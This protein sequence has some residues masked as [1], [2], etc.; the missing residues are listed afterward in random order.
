M[1]SQLLFVD[2]Y[3]DTLE[4]P[5][6]GEIGVLPVEWEH[7]QIVQHLGAQY[8]VVR[9]LGRGGMG[10]VFLARDIALHRLVAIKVCGSSSRPRSNTASASA[11]KR[12]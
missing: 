10:V 1:S 9:E 4:L 11:A 7:D 2:P 12:A 8:Q 3:A 5:V 6:T